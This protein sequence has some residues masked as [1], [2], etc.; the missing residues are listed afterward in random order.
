V[1]SVLRQCYG[2]PSAVTDELVDV[3]L[4]PG[5]EP[6][7]V[8]VFLDFISYSSGPLPEQLL[9]EAPVP[10]SVVWGEEDPWEKI[11]WGREFAK[12]DTVQ[13][14]CRCEGVGRGVLARLLGGGWE[15]A[16]ASL[17]VG[18]GV[19]F[20]FSCP[21]AAAAAATACQAPVGDTLPPYWQEFISLPG[22][23]HC[24]HDEAPQLVNPLIQKF[25]QRVCA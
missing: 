12:Y 4:K 9:A 1:R 2:D 19:C 23:G 8:N 15:G 5:L 24:P 6:G 14:G 11:E 18:C 20:F 21:A 16:L 7:A 10:V 17:A 3:I 13:V 22:V 25:V